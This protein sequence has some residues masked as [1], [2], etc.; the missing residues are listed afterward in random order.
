MESSAGP[1]LGG[2]PILLLQVLV[3]RDPSHTLAP[4]QSWSTRQVA[5]GPLL[6][7]LGILSWI[8]SGT[9]ICH[10]WVGQVGS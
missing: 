9:H 1:V 5:L 2:A 10:S 6:L 8:L 7:S 4:S 3:P